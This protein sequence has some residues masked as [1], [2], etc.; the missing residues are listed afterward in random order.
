MNITILV[1]TYYEK[2]PR[3]L[4]NYF[5]KEYGKIR[6]EDVDTLGARIELLKRRLA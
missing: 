6:K 4:S 2:L 1:N 5:Q 3:K